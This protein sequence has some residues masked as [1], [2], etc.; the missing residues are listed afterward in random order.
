MRLGEFK[1]KS[2]DNVELKRFVYFP[3]CILRAFSYF[4][5]RSILRGTHSAQS[6]RNGFDMP[7]LRS[8]C[9]PKTLPSSMC[10]RPEGVEL[11]DRAPHR[12]LVPRVEPEGPVQCQES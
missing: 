11:Q 2:S 5:I 6:T 8:Q 4:W 7:N 10:H 12:Q 9:D 1:A 3:F